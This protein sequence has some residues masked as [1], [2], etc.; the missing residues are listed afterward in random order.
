MYNLSIQIQQ[1]L[2]VCLCVVSVSETDETGKTTPLARSV[3]TSAI[4]RDADQDELHI[5]C[6]QAIDAVVKALSTKG[7]RVWAIENE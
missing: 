7:G 2:S 6:E 4:G 3:T 1:H 5:F